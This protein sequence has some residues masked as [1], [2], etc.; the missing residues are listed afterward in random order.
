M[1]CLSLWKSLLCRKTSWTLTPT[2]VD[3]CA[4]RRQ[5]NGRRLLQNR[6]CRPVAML[7]LVFCAL[8][9]LASQL[10]LRSSS[11]DAANSGS[12]GANAAG[13]LGAGLPDAI[14]VWQHMRCCICCGC[15]GSLAKS[16]RAYSLAMVI[17]VVWA[18]ALL[19]L[20][21]AERCG[22]QCQSMVA[23]CRIGPAAVGRAAAL[24][25]AGRQT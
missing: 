2:T 25:A 4:C 1:R 18:A 20:A 8:L 15:T 23:A 24:P 21:R 3:F 14:K 13:E 10:R 5:R 9:L 16:S 12:S 7:L 22:S 17:A 11:G 19:G 6:L